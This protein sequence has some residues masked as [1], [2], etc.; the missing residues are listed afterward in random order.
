MNTLN[1]I[2]SLL[3]PYAFIHI[4]DP[5]PCNNEILNI[6]PAL[7]LLMISVIIHLKL[8][9][10][11]HVNRNIIRYVCKIKELKDAKKDYKLYIEDTEIESEVKLFSNLFQRTSQF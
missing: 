3:L 5:L 10:Y 6:V 11:A 2:A 1:I 8:I 4:V 9:S 7:I